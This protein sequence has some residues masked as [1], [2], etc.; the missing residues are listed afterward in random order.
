MKKIEGNLAGKGQKVG[1]IVARFNDFINSSGLI[2]PLCPPAWLFTATNASAPKL[3]TFLAKAKSVTSQNTLVP[4]LCASLIVSS[5]EPNEVKI[6]STFSS[7][8]IRNC[9]LYFTLDLFTIKLNYIKQRHRITIGEKRN[10]LIR[11]R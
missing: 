4:T 9:S 11:L 3:S 2:F 10:K 5:G 8:K 7:H 1:I 6:K